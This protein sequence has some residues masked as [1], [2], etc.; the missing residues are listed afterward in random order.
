MFTNMTKVQN[1]E[2][3]LEGIHIQHEESI[4]QYISHFEDLMQKAG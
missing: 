1:A 2:A 4:D 3:A